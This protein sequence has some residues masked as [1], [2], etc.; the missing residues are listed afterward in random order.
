MRSLFIAFL[1]L[2]TCLVSAQ[3]QYVSSTEQVTKSMHED[4]KVTY[5][6]LREKKVR[7]GK[8]VLY[9]RGKKIVEGTYVAGKMHGKWTRYYINGTPSIKAFYLQGKKHGKWEYFYENKA[10]LSQV[11]FNRGKK[12]G[13]WSSYYADG[14]PMAAWHFENDSLIGTQQLFYSSQDLKDGAPEV[15]LQLK[16]H[17]SYANGERI[18]KKEKYYPNGKLFETETVKG[19]SRIGEF[20]RFY[21]SG[22]LWMSFKYE[23]DGRLYSIFDFNNPIGRDADRGSFRDGNGELKLYNSDGKLYSVTSYSNGLKDGKMTI[24]EVD[25]SVRMTGYFN[26]GIETGTWKQYKP[27]TSRTELQAEWTYHGVDTITGSFY[28]GTMKQRHEGVMINKKFNGLWKTYHPNGDVS[29]R[30]ER[31]LGFDHGEE[32][33]FKERNV[34]EVKGG[35][36]FGLKIGSWR[37]YNDYGKVTFREEFI[38]E[39]NGIESYLYSDSCKNSPGTELT[40]YNIPSHISTYD[41]R[42]AFTRN[43]D[44]LINFDHFLF[45]G[46][47]TTWPANWETDAEKIKEYEEK[48]MVSFPRIIPWDVEA[49]MNV[50]KDYDLGL[51]V[52]TLD[53]KRLRD[54]SNKTSQRIGVA[55]LVLDLDEFGTV[56]RK[57]VVRG[58]GEKWDNKLLEMFDFYEFLE[59]AFLMNIPT[60]TAFQRKVPIYEKEVK[61]MN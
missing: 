42:I 47:K 2:N 44:R 28:S 41:R 8:Y 25:G 49:R 23:E 12:T 27:I 9:H 3:H 11:F 34:L 55:M 40:L 30:I 15:Q 18:L 35:N 60:E 16:V 51:L 54:K 43:D 17:V 52:E 46:Q 6:Q 39:A 1:L 24:Y 13:N 29:G 53:P 36:Y 33:R 56:N 61:N 31:I 14:V 50:V 48:F 22:M 10:L 32:E 59:P 38:T 45:N 5:E 26:D 20:K 19:E 37:Y 7:H 57:R 58:V 4:F 21:E